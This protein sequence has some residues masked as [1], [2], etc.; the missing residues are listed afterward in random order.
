MTEKWDELK[1]YI[2]E[3]IE[4]VD[5]YY[6]DPNE[7]YIRWKTLKDVLGAMTLLKFREENQND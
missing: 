7:N 1:E 5:E 6:S 2:Q 3:Q 4:D